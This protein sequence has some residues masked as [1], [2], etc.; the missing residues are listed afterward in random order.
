[1]PCVR[2]VEPS[3]PM[4]SGHHGW[5]DM[6]KGYPYLSLYTLGDK[7]Y[8]AN[9]PNQLL[10]S[11]SNRITTIFRLNM[12]CVVRPAHLVAGQAL[13]EDTRGL[14][15][16]V[17]KAV[18]PRRREGNWLGKEKEKKNGKKKEKEKREEIKEKK[19]I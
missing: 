6:T 10:Y 18:Q 15:P 2:D 12:P 5:Y 9:S 13:L 7:I 11:I 1:M 17:G 14:P 19:R 8:M 4:V 3:R 16:S